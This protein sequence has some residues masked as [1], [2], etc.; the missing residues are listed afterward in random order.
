[1]MYDLGLM[2]H[3]VEEDQRVFDDEHKD[4]TDRIEDMKK[5]IG[6]AVKELKES[7]KGDTIEVR[8]RKG[9]VKWQTSWLE[10]YSV[11]HPEILKYRT[12][13]KPTVAFV[14]RDEGWDDDGR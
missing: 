12:E 1:M 10:G 14:L 3:K 9:A 8:Y 2:M 4:V 7:I 6:D 11:D 5:V 13:G